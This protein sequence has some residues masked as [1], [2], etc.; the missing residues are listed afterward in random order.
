MV[1]L[2]VSVIIRTVGE[3]T[4]KACYDIVACQVPKDQISFVS[5]V[6]FAKTLKKSLEL[7]I[8]KDRKWT[9]CIDADVLLKHSAISDLIKIGETQPENVVEI[10]GGV[11]DKFFFGPRPAGNHLYKTQHLVR[12]LE[13]IEDFNSNI[14]PEH[15]MLN[16]L[17]E[18]GLVW[19]NINVVVGLHDFEQSNFDIFRKCVVQA[20][21]HSYHIQK[22]YERWSIYQNQDLDFKIALAGLGTGIMLDSVE[23]TTGDHMVEIYNMNQKM[24]NWN[25]KKSLEELPNVDEIEL[26]YL[27][28]VDSSA[29]VPVMK[30]QYDKYYETEAIP[31]QITEK[32]QNRNLYH[33]LYRISKGISNRLYT[34]SHK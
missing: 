11:L 6:P 16:R 10:Q 1:N 23:S 2:D 20:H 32:F 21:K 31:N 19:K 29:I 28:G 25:E 7:G 17:A 30:E 14:R 18:Q 4:Q 12:A 33:F 26:N 34:L 27:K 15:T 13:V 22:L 3:R 5:E 8:E 9:L 24:F